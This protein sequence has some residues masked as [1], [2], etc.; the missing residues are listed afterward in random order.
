MTNEEFATEMIVGVNPIVI[1]LFKVSANILCWIILLSRAMGHVNGLIKLLN[2]V[3]HVVE[4]III[5]YFMKQEHALE[6]DEVVFKLVWE[7][8]LSYVPESEVAM[9]LV[10]W[11]E[12]EIDEH[13]VLEFFLSFCCFFVCFRYIIVKIYGHRNCRIIHHPFI[14]L[15][16]KLMLMPQLYKKWG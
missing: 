2:Q 8:R 10:L 5:E 11:A 15:F 16:S 6:R 9:W 13:L 3:D 14:F 4:T 7:E 12:W 1:R